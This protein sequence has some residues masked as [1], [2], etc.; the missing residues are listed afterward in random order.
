[1][2]IALFDLDGTLVD[3]DAALLA[4]FT[5]LAVPADRVPP[6]GLPLVEACALAGVTV[7]EY[8]D[9]YDATAVKPFPGVEDLLAQLPRWAVCS[10][11][12]RASG[13]QELQRL[14]WAPELALFSDDF[15]GQQKRLQPVLDALALVPDDVLFVGDTAHDRECAAVVGAR[16]ALAAW[17]PRVQPGPDDLVLHHPADVLD[18]LG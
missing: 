6:L 13:V 8:L 3:S 12:A 18:L 10:N 14:G 1:V 17:N 11:K 2:A 4:P 9:L 15:G 16:F 7:D 5:A